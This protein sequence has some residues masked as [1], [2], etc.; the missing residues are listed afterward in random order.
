M[1]TG[2]AV[3]AALGSALCF[4]TSSVLQQRGAARAPRGSGL[5][6][7]LL[8]HLVTRPVWLAGAT[9]ALGTLALQALA[10]S[11]GE[12]VLVQPVLIAG[13][14]FALPLS[15]VLEGR[16]PS[17]HEW[18]WAVVLVVGL[19]TFLLAARPRSGPR[20]PDEGRLW[21]YMIV[22]LAVA[23]TVAVFGAAVG[24]R[25]RAALLG[26]ATGL[27]YGVTAALIKFCCDLSA[28]EGIGWLV[29]SWPFYALLIVGAVGI[30]LNQAA[31]QAGPLSGALPTIAITDP[32][33][34]MVCGVGIFG[35]QVELGRGALLGQLLGF[36]LMVAAIL[37]LARLS[38]GRH[39]TEP[40]CS[41][42]ARQER[43]LATVRTLTPTQRVPPLEEA[44]KL[45]VLAGGGEQLP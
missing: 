23:L 16:R 36:A 18:G 10:L 21:Q 5:H 15:V 4:S 38:A 20:W 19:V 41:D 42:T 29:A 17:L 1:N 9:A 13:L 3:L 26:A 31:Y 37:R 32:L 30:V 33:V 43:E 24:G 7:D 27:T 44:A 6:L 14:L 25:H 35:E 45:D 11:S 2:L 12:L 8:L 34:A 39:P 22:V 28:R 40:R